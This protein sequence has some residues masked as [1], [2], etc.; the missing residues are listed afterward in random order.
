VV[1]TEIHER[2]NTPETLKALRLATAV[3]R[4]GHPVDCPGAVLFMA[5]E[6]AS[7]VTGSTLA[8]NGVS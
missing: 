8:V 1:H 7:Y 5:S 6:A 4:L 3:K 2:T